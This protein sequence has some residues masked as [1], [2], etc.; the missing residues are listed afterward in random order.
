MIGV[1]CLCMQGGTNQRRCCS[2]SLRLCS[3]PD[4]MRP[5]MNKNNLLESSHRLRTETSLAKAN[6]CARRW[7]LSHSG[8]L[9]SHRLILSIRAFSSLIRDGRTSHGGQLAPLFCMH[10]SS[11]ILC[12]AKIDY[13]MHVAVIQVSQ[14]WQSKYMQRG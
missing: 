6:P 12:L 8:I 10:P 11:V 5:V 7:C 2:L 1:S 14:H 4:M 13:S 9:S 3:G